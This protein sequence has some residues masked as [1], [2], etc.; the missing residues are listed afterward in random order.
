MSRETL[1]LIMNST[2]YFIDIR[3]LALLEMKEKY[4]FEFPFIT[5]YGLIRAIPTEWKR[6]ALRDTTSEHGESQRR[7][8]TLKFFSTK[9]AYSAI[10][11]KSFSAPFAEGRILNRG[12]TKEKIPNMH[13]YMLPFKILETTKIDH[14]PG[15]NYSQH[16]TY[17][18]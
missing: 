16:L 2:Y 6:S 4:N 9:D 18:I 12:L 1:I 14:V 8:T 13:M 15:Q 3:F 10:L 11:G 7:E 17:S 5:Y